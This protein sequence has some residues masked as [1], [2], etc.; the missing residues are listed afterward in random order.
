MRHINV[1]TNMYTVCWYSFADQ[2]ASESAFCN[3]DPAKLISYT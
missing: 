3:L 1:Y 2:S